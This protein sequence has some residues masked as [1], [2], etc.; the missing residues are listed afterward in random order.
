MTTRVR[1]DQAL[2]HLRDD[3]LMMGSRV[4]E[5]LNVA[6]A[7]Y[8]H[9]D[10]ERV[11]QVQAADKIINRYR[12]EIEERC[13]TLICTQQPAARDLRQ[14]FAAMSMVVD[15]ERMGDQA[16]GIAKV[17][18]HLAGHPNRPAPPEL[19][20]MGEKV[21]AMLRQGMEA[22]A[23]GNADLAAQVGPQDEEV[24]LM[25]GQV[26]TQVMEFMVLEADVVDSAQAGYSVLRVGRELER[27][28]DLAVNVADR[29]IYILRGSVKG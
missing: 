12:A 23:T 6:L 10:V 14:I 28:G 24:D 21:N 3:I 27:F 15:L 20:P 13:F 17:I 25:L 18:P 16:K 29:V 26:F 19:L 2:S 7:A 5:E 1:F 22:Y 11:A 9:M 4:E 8:K